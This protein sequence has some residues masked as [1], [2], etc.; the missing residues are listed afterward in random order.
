MSKSSLVGLSLL[1]GAVVQSYISLASA[2]LHEG[3]ALVASHENASAVKLDALD[4]QALEGLVKQADI[5][6]RYTLFSCYHPT[7]KFGT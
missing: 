3:A 5:V 4:P 1:L 2:I 7:S 6:I